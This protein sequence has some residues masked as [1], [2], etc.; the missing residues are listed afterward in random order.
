[1]YRPINGN[2]KIPLLVSLNENF[3]SPMMKLRAQH[4]NI[5]CATLDHNGKLSEN[6]VKLYPARTM[7]K[8]SFFWFVFSHIWTEYGD[9]QNTGNTGKY[10]PE[11]LHIGTF[12]MQ[13]RLQ[14]RPFQL[15][16]S[17][18]LWKVAFLCNFL[19]SVKSVLNLW[20]NQAAVS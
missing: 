13:K 16:R 2:I 17:S 12:F 14:G 6:F 10:G 3:T 18:D 4:T 11:K 19:Q 1:M 5:L 15:T 8:Y 9:L 7:S 20:C